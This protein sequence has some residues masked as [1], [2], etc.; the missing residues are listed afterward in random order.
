MNDLL[1]RRPPVGGRPVRSAASLL[2]L[3]VALPRLRRRHFAITPA[4]LVRL[5]PV[6]GSEA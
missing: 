1:T 3:D 2:L 4:W 5:G 6:S